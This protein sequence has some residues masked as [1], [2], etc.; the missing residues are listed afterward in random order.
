MARR[1]L[2][3]NGMAT[4]NLPFY[5]AAAYGFSALFLWTNRYMDVPVP[6]YDQVGS[7]AYIGLLL[8]RNLMGFS[9]PAFLF[10][11]GF[12]GAFASEGTDGGAMW[13]MVATRIKK[14]LVPYVLWTTATFVILRQIPGP[15]EALAMYYFITLMIQYY[16]LSPIL[17]PL[18]KKRWILLLIVSAI[19]QL[20]LQLLRH[21]V[22]LGIGFPGLDLLISLSPIW[23]FPSRILMFAIGAVVGA[24]LEEAMGWLRKHFTLL[25]VAA[26]VSG[27]LMPIEYQWVANHSPNGWPGSDFFGLS[28]TIFS[29]CIVLVIIAA[30]KLPMPASLSRQFIG[31][32]S[33]SLGVYLANTPV[34]YVAASLIYHLAPSLLGVQIIYQSILVSLGLFAPLIG[35]SIIKR[36]PLS[37]AYGYVFG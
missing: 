28:R 33:K 10:I 8:I 5:H 30:S 29:I 24:H 7:A 3:L 32:G 4:L 11:V 27:V 34:L 22:I 13:R 16:V 37:R 31:L 26:I 23:F 2:I 12:Y 21:L 19:I 20:G 18:A 14:L 9:I 15:S 17:L 25:V 36:P 6:N 35:M 1:L